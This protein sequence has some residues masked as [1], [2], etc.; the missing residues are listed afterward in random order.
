MSVD[1]IIAAL[2]TQHQESPM[3]TETDLLPLPPLHIAPSVEPVDY[4]EVAQALMDYARANVA[5][6][7]A[8]LQAEIEALRAEAGRL[9][10][11]YDER[12]ACMIVHRGQALAC[13]DAVR[14]AYFDESRRADK[15]WEE[16]GRLRAEVE[17]LR[18]IISDIKDWDCD[19]SGGFLSIPVGLRRRMQDALAAH[20]RGGSDN[21]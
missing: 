7:T 12:T 1:Q 21:E 3:T 4:P 14:A 20:R 10:Q 16:A 15:L 9:Q 11:Q 2:A 5:H 6:A 13:S 19:V 17:R 8:P 18:S